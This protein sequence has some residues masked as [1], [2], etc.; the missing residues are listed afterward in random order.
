MSWWLIWLLWA[1]IALNS[2]LA[3]WSLMLVQRIRVLSRLLGN[4]CFQAFISQHLPIWRPWAEVW[5]VHLS[6]TA[7]QQRED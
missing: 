6:I 1:L 3:L 5:G 2:A 7:E 4:L